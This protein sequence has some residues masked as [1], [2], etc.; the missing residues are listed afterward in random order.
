MMSQTMFPALENM[1]IRLSQKYL[2]PIPSETINPSPLLREAQVLD[3]NLLLPVRFLIQNLQFGFEHKP[4]IAQNPFAK[5]IL[6]FDQI[7]TL[8]TVALYGPKTFT[9]IFLTASIAKYFVD[10][11]LEMKKIPHAQ[12]QIMPYY[13]QR[14]Y[15][16]G[17]KMFSHYI[18]DNSQEPWSNIILAIFL[19]V[20]QIQV[21]A[22]GE[23]IL[24]SFKARLQT[25][26][27][28]TPLEDMQLFQYLFSSQ[29]Y[30][31]F[32]SRIFANFTGNPDPWF[33]PQP[34]QPENNPF[35]S[36]P[37]ISTGG[38]SAPPIQI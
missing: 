14:L 20:F 3:P 35:M 1:F 23:T 10:L 24:N 38:L 29:N 36:P 5:F 19:A 18:G 30:Q 21:G 2:S 22:H 15:T 7:Y 26:D 17:T 9:K 13:Q 8:S 31:E 11:F 34:A 6:R 37:R 4:E 28:E 25:I 16:Y 27:P 33:I 32:L 12:S